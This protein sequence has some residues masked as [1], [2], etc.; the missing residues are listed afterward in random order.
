MEGLFRYLIEKKRPKSAALVKVGGMNLPP[1][2]LSN[3]HKAPGIRG[4]NTTYPALSNRT[5]M[6]GVCFPIS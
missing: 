4:R 3:E 5:V 2:T 1:V 6:Q